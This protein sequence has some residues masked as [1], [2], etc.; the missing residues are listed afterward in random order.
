MERPDHISEEF[1]A[2]LLEIWAKAKPNPQ[3]QQPAQP[4]QG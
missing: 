3:P 1:W 2:K 4:A